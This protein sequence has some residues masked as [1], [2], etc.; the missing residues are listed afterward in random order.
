MFYLTKIQLSKEFVVEDIHWYISG[1]N[2]GKRSPDDTGSCYKQ[3]NKFCNNLQSTNVF[4]F[5]KFLVKLKQSCFNLNIIS[6]EEK[7]IMEYDISPIIEIHERTLKIHHL[8]SSKSQE[9]M[10]IR[11]LSRLIEA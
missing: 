2:Y 1:G 6:V 9:S 5:K 11:S 8:V 7:T 10:E 4:N 3:N